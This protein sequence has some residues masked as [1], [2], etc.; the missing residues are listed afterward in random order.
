VRILVG[1]FVI[2]VIF[3]QVDPKALLRK[4][5]ENYDHTW[6]SGMEWA[7]TTTD[8]TES[9]GEKDVT[10]TEVI[11]IAGTPYDRVVVKAGQKLKG[12]DAAREEQKFEKTCR[13][14]EKESPAERATRLRK[15]ESQHAFAKE[16]PNA[17]DAK[18]VGEETIEGRP[19]WVIQLTPR[20]DFHPLSMRAAMLKHIGARLWIDK[21]DV[22][23]VKAQAHV[24]DTLSIG[25]VLARIGPGADITYEQTRVGDGL[26]MPKKIRIEGVAKIFLVHDKDLTE[27]VTFTG[28]HQPEPPVLSAS[29]PADRRAYSER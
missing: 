4:S 29:R 20:A 15:F 1:L 5:V 21:Q 26:W 22:Q 16:V 10:V 27:T 17:Y 25:W 28:Y 8:V 23:W 6:R 14:R 7:Y 13:E 18:L 12:A 2:P 9:G 19:T 24:I 11:P 3:G